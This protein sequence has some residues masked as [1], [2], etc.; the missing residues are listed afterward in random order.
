MNNV[1]YMTSYKMC[2]WHPIY[3]MDKS[4]CDEFGWSQNEFKKALTVIDRFRQN[5]SVNASDCPRQNPKGREI[6]EITLSNDHH[7]QH[8]VE[9]WW[10]VD[11]KDINSWYITQEEKITLKRY[12]WDVR[13][14]D[15]SNAFG[16]SRL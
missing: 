7:P 13:F 16:V 2:T 4:Q 11:N 10:W 12:G 14:K 3:K 8:H 5:A 15:D 1:D 9:S 6:Y